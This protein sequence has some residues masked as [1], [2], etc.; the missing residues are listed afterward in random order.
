M[1]TK[2]TLAA[3]NQVFV[4]S[5]VSTVLVRRQRLGYNEWLWVGMREPAVPLPLAA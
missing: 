5:L 3:R 1:N 2:A 4:D